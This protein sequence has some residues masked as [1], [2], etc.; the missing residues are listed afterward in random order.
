MVEKSLSLR[1]RLLQA[2]YRAGASGLTAFEASELLAEPMGSIWSAIGALLDDDL[3]EVD[4]D[5]LT[6][7]KVVRMSPDTGKDQQVRV[8]TATGRELVEELNRGID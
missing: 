1:V 6:C 2:H 7:Q 4:Y 3:V 8:L 5:L